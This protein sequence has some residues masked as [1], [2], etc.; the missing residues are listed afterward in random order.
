MRIIK[1]KAL[2]K[3]V[4]MLPDYKEFWVEGLLAI[5]GCIKFP[6]EIEGC[7]IDKETICQNTGVKDKNG[8]EIYENDIVRYYTDYPHSDSHWDYE[9]EYVRG[10]FMMNGCG[11]SYFDNSR[12]EV[13][14]NKFDIKK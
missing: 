7:F 2:T 1:F 11:I 13:V 3:N 9:V 6:Y 5:S 14:G 8:R 10:G 12:M 4:N